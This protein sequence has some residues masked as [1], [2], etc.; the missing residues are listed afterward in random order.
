[1]NLI[2]KPLALLQAAKTAIKEAEEQNNNMKNMQV[3]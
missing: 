3:C 2:H 1:M